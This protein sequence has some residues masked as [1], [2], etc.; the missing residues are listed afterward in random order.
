MLEAMAAGLP[1]IASRLPAHE[2]FLINEQTGW[3]C[4]T[5]VDF[6]KGIDQLEDIDVNRR[7][8]NAAREWVAEAVG[9]W[10]DCAARYIRIYNRLTGK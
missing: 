6:S 3:L 4:G 8:G 5:P 9:T 7:I 10:S 2:N 1:I